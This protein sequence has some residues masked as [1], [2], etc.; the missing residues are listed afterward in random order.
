MTTW[1]DQNS[2]ANRRA[3]DTTDATVFSYAKR[4]ADHE[5]LHFEQL[6][7]TLEP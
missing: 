5:V 2:A 6:R 4:I 3:A 7:R 1:P